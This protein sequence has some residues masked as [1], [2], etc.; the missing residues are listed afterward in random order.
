MSTPKKKV[1]YKYCRACY[2]LTFRIREEKGGEGLTQIPSMTDDALLT[3]VVAGR[4][5]RAPIKP[6]E[7][8]WLKCSSSFPIVDNDHASFMVFLET[9]IQAK[10]SE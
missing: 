10:I 2:T 4:W 8:V 1:P 9:T 7:L 6:C 3:H 5:N